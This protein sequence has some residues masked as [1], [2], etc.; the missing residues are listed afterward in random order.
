VLWFFLPEPSIAW[1][2]R[3][4]YLALTEWP[5][6]ANI[7]RP[8]AVARDGGSA[9]EVARSVSP[10]W[11][12][13]SSAFGGVVA[14][15]LPKRIALAG[16]YTGQALLCFAAPLLF[17]TSDLVVLIFLILGVNSLAQVSSP[18]ESSVLPLVATEEELASAASLINLAVAGGNGFATAIFAPFLVRAFGVEPAIYQSA[19]FFWPPPPASSTSRSAIGPGR[20]AFRRCV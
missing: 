3:S 14:D 13:H 1:D 15:A 12:R 19:Y 2:T 16:A 9:L 8:V 6:N 18:S 10:D 20:P 7:R 11:C 17:D 5:A 4:P